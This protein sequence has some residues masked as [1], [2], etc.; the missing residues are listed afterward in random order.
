MSRA[1]LASPALPK[2]CEGLRDERIGVTL[3]N[4]FKF[5]NLDAMTIAEELDALRG[6]GAR[7][8]EPAAFTLDGLVWDQFFNSNI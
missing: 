1:V 5:E 3:A 2:A 4:G 7:P 6:Q 8:F